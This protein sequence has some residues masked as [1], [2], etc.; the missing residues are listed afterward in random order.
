[1]FV[2]DLDDPY[3]LNLSLTV[4]GFLN[5]FTRLAADMEGRVPY[6]VRFIAR[7]LNEPPRVVGKAL[8]TCIT[9]GLITEFNAGVV[10]TENKD[11]D[12]E[13]ATPSIPPS[14]SLSNSKSSRSSTNSN[15]TT[16]L[17]VVN[18]DSDACLHC[19]SEGCHWCEPS[20][21]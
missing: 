4:R 11:I 9:L 14:L 18:D 3:Y 20:L 16:V 1:M 13:L 8:Q 10:S 2:R 12:E 21:E 19:D 6:D 5:D 7:R 15:T 17:Q